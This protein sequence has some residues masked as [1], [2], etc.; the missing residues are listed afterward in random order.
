MGGA[1]R[2]RLRRRRERDVGEADF[3]RKLFAGNLP[4]DVTDDDLWDFFG[5]MGDDGESRPGDEIKAIRYLT[6]RETDEFKG[7]AYIE[8][9]STRDADAAARLNGELLKGRPIR[10]DWGA[11]L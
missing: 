11:G 5:R 7:C 3:C 8:F 6:H 10:L 9:N 1:G 2:R 4:Y